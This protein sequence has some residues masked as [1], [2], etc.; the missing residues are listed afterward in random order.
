MQVRNAC[1]QLGNGL[2]T[3]PKQTVSTN[4]SIYLLCNEYYILTYLRTLKKATSKM[5]MIYNLY[6]RNTS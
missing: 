3:M 4:S 2:L 5:L 1:G 6:F